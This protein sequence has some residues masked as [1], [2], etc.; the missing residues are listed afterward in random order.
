MSKAWCLISLKF[1]FAILAKVLSI[2]LF[3]LERLF[4]MF[5]LSSSNDSIVLK[6]NIVEKRFVILNL[7]AS[8]CEE[9]LT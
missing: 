2:T 1:S 4:S 5:T 8:N 9:P 6:T 7:K 3:P